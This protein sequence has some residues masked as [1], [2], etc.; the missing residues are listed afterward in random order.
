LKF[1][2]LLLGSGNRL[3]TPLIAW[4]VASSLSTMATIALIS[5]MIGQDIGQ[6]VELQRLGLFLFI[7]ALVV[8]SQYTALNLTAEVV[9]Q[10]LEQLQR[11]LAAVFRSSELKA[12]ETVGTARINGIMERTTAVLG[13]AGP[14]VIHGLITSGVMVCLGAYVL[15]LSPF[16]FAVM[17]LLAAGTVYI[18]RYYM[19]A[20]IK[21]QCR[22]REIERRHLDLFVQMLDGFKEVKL[23]W[24]RGDD[25]QHGFMEAASAEARLTKRR[26]AQ[27]AN[28]AYSVGYAGFYLLLATV[29]FAL[30]QYFDNREAATKITYITLFLMATVN[31]L[32][33]AL[34][35]LGRANA[36]LVELEQLKRQLASFG[37]DEAHADRIWPSDF[38]SV[39]LTAVTHRDTLG[40]PLLG[41]FDLELRPG[42]VTLI[43]GPNG[44]GKT[45]LL[46]LLTGLYAPDSGR[47]RWN[48]VPVEQRRL[49]GYRA[50]FAAVFDDCHLFDRAYGL[51]PDHA[52][53]LPDMLQTLGIPPHQA[54]RPI[55]Q[56]ALASTAQRRR[57][58]LAVALLEERPIL[59]LDDI[60]TGQDRDFRQ[61]L[62]GTLLPALRAASTCVVIT[63]PGDENLAKAADRVLLLHHDLPIEPSQRQACP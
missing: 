27:R 24:R 44:C 16:A 15:Y 30:P 36:T 26:T 53:R 40:G 22:A 33:R 54:R 7:S 28:R 47:I 43:T 14:P 57:A 17:V 21:E 49:P 58:A 31:V 34:P 19:D 42:H 20:V 10:A 25:L 37:T 56:L 61:Y 5:E 4:L 39:R 9:E 48:G 55:A 41:P 60:L 52:A 63:T 3:R 35:M 1:L 2:Q 6:P 45:T 18:F 13:E 12:V 29:V 8:Y 46:R 23:N 50:L 59:V 38:E 51:D 62:I 11:E 32:M